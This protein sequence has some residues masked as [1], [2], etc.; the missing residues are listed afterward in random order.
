[1]V[2]LLKSSLYGLKR[3]PRQWNR[4]FDEYMLKIGFIRSNFDRCIYLKI[5]VTRN[6]VFLLLYVDDM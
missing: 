1:M 3:S 6:L 4:K 5:K 2:C